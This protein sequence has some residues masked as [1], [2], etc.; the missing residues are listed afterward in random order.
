MK[1]II[2]LS[3]ISVI[4]IGCKQDYIGQYP[5]HKTP[6]PAVSNVRVQNLPGSAILTYDLPDVDDLFYIKA[7]YT[8]TRGE[9]KE[10]SSS[11]YSNNIVLK[12]FG[13][14]QKHQVSLIS[15]D[16][17]YNESQ[18]VIVEIEPLD[19][20]IYD[21]F[22][23]LEVA[24]SFGGVSLFWENPLSENLVFEALIKDE[25]DGEY[26]FIE[27]IYSSQAV[28]QRF[29]RGLESKPTDFAF[30]F[31][32]TYNNYTDTFFVNLT[33]IFEEKLDK[34][35][36]VP[37]PLSNKFSYHSHGGRSMT[38]MWDNIYNVNGNLFY[39]NA[40]PDTIYF[41]FDMGVEAKLSRFKLWTRLDY[42]YQLHHLKEFE[43]WG[44]SD[45]EATT[46]P[47]SWEGWVKIMYCESS[48]P[49]GLPEGD[50]PTA[51]D[52]E[53]ALGGE[54]WEVPIGAPAFRYMRFKVLRTWTNSRSAFIN[55]IDIWGS[56]Q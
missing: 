17:S 48:R 34:S 10:M 7:V 3:L 9:K 1:K 49:S 52:V 43:I 54:E 26:E 5:V 16:K 38:R 2:V 14:G 46:D 19:S 50:P 55:E 11:A 33:P 27:T 31:R 12:G 37:L 4:I 41:S 23:S 44:T 20:P 30:Y 24:E 36:F 13:K 25:A 22:Q 53:Y 29:I 51:E 56:T 35:K 47:D 39:L 18:P 6:P 32:D 45:P 28:A 42:A 8:N 40:S 15:V 21:V